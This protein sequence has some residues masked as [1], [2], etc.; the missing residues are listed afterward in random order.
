MD[1]IYIYIHKFDDKYALFQKKK[2]DDKSQKHKSF[3]Y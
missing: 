1:N 3:I 2:F